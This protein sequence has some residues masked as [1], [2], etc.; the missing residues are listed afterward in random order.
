MEEKKT[1]NI[2]HATPETMILN[3]K[4]TGAILNK[5]PNLIGSVQF[6]VQFQYDTN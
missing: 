6:G 3:L 2:L 5:Q 4:S 1:H